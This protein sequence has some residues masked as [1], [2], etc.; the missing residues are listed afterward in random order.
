[1]RVLLC[2]MKE[3]GKY[4]SFLGWT[5]QITYTFLVFF[6]PTFTFLLVVIQYW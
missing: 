5:S 1:M 4:S 3:K 2:L 6:L